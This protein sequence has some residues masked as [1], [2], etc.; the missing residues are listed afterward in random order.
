VRGRIGRSALRRAAVLA[1]LA[2]AGVAPRAD[3]QLPGLADPG[4]A[5]ALHPLVRRTPEL[6][7]RQAAVAA[8]E[9]RVSAA[10]LA[11]AASL[12]VEIEEVPG[13][14]DVLDAGSARVGV[15][16]ELVAGPLRR[17][18][19][20]VAR[21]ELERVRLELEL[22]ERSL[23]ARVDQLLV[24]AAAGLAIARRLGDEDALLADAERALR[25]RFTVGDARYVDVLRLR[26]ERLR[27]QGERARATADARV[28]RRALLALAGADG[29][30]PTAVVDS[31]IGAQL[32]AA[33]RALPAVPG[34]DSLLRVAGFVRLAAVEVAH[35]EAARR[36]A[37]AQR[38]PGVVASIGVQRFAREEGGHGVGPTIGA[39]VTLPFTARRAGAAARTVAEREVA[40]AA[41]NR[42]AAVAH[43]R[44]ELAS[45]IERY[46]AARAQ[47]ALHDA[48]LLGAAR[49][50]REGALASYRSGALSL[51]ELLDFERALARAEIDRLRS[52]MEAADA[53][54]D[55]VAGVA[56]VGEDAHGQPAERR[57]GGDG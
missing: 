46:E 16:R 27:V 41:A 44:H 28:A 33:E 15:S 43:V 38:R 6:A 3:A 12:D 5:A 45:A 49:E 20:E 56:G 53:L 26:S 47:L 42:R 52:R 18:R 34:L 51:I 54:A 13:G 40:A 37:L 4:A 31:A 7:A 9:A 1:A 14:V 24:E 23:L 10:G 17:A 11:A 25:P 21:R 19:R 48:T 57:A 32:A 39:S 8:A 2:A 30:D 55:L 35:A 50:E 22:V 29:E 36:L